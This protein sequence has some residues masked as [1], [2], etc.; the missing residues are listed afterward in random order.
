[1]SSIYSTF[2][3]YRNNQNSL[4]DMLTTYYTN[5]IELLRYLTGNGSCSANKLEPIIS[6]NNIQYFDNTSSILRNIIGDS[7]NTVNIKAS[8]GYIQPNFIPNASMVGNEVNKNN[9]YRLFLYIEYTTLTSSIPTYTTLT[10]GKIIYCTDKNQMYSYVNTCLVNTFGNEMEL[11]DTNRYVTFSLFDKLYT[12]VLNKVSQDM[13]IDKYSIF[14]ILQNYYFCNNS[15]Y[16]DRTDISMCNSII[17]SILRTHINYTDLLE[18]SEI[19]NGY[20]VMV[21][22][23]LA[24]YKYIKTYFS[25]SDINEYCN[26]TELG[27]QRY[28]G[29]INK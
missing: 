28:L 13:N 9:M 7:Y 20:F 17:N 24:K 14:R 10:G 22:K 3:R 4:R 19:Y 11:L 18:K 12:I 5:D 15:S 6:L 1:M 8:Y 26:M 16:Y 27:L 2:N 23:A 25:Y 21:Y 29:L